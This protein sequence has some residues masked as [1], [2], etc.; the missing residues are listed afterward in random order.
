MADDN[1]GRMFEWDENKRLTN[2]AK[3]GIDFEDAKEV[4]SDQ[5]AFSFASARS[6]EER[7]YVTVGL[8]KERLIAVIYTRRAEVIRII[9]ARAARQSERQRYG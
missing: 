6:T 1:G 2:I 9:S 5:A 7:R 8:S 3:H 4:F